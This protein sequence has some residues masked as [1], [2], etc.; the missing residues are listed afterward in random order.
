MKLYTLMIVFLL[1]V[2]QSSIVQANNDPEHL[3]QSCQELVS[4]Y[5][6]RGEKH[7]TAGLTTSLSEALRAGY[8]MGVV[9]EYRR[10]NECNTND[11]LRQAQ[12]IAELPLSFAKRASV[13]QLLGISCDI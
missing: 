10:R 2:L 6:K 3:I 11:W 12:A 9:D 7:L 13:E 5:T 1:N 8:C 4:I